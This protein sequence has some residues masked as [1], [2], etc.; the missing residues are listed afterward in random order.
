M[1][2]VRVGVGAI[3]AALIAVGGLLLLRDGNLLAVAPWVV[4]PVIVHDLAIGP[5][6]IA[7]VWMGVRYLPLYA[8]TPAMFGV[9]VSG[10]LTLV[11]IS[12]VGRQGASPDNASLLNRDYLSGW[13][14]VITLTWVAVLASALM[15]RGWR[16]RRPEGHGPATR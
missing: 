8:R 7:L 6:V 9:V 16:R 15:R 1:N 4:V 5:L 2:R 10:A 13:L 14:V 3:G 12:V 11:A